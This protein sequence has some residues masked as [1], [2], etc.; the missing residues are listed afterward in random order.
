ML[1]ADEKSTQ[2]WRWW[3]Q[4]GR[5]EFLDSARFSYFSFELKKEEVQRLSPIVNPG[6]CFSVFFAGEHY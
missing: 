1:R 4:S 6:Y 5:V 2:V 3:R